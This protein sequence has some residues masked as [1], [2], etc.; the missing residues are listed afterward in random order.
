MFSLN[1]LT[2]SGVRDQFNCHKFT[3]DDIIER[4]QLKS[5]KITTTAVLAEAGLKAGKIN[6]E[7]HIGRSPHKGER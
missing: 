1:I 4:I 6:L 3:V 5:T 7:G 2:G